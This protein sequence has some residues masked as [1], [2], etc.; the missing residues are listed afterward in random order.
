MQT[1]VLTLILMFLNAYRSANKITISNR[2]YFLYDDYFV[3]INVVFYYFQ[4]FVQLLLKVEFTTK[5]I[6]T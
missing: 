6:T 2:I 3:V 5:K 1:F 4:V